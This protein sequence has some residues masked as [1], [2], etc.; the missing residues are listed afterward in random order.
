MVHPN[1][2]LDIFLLHIT[3][4]R[5]FLT[6]MNL[7]LKILTNYLLSFP[8]ERTITGSPNYSFN[9][10]K[11][12]LIFVNDDFDL[13]LQSFGI[14]LRIMKFLKDFFWLLFWILEMLGNHARVSIASD[15]ALE[16]LCLI[17]KVIILIYCIHPDCNHDV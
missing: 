15:L 14:F 11:L 6:T 12:M 4:L 7:H 10:V 9:S 2:I 1:D 16:S 13:I 8:Q 5:H 3:S 17:N